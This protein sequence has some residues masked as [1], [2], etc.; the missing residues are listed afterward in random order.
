VAELRIAGLSLHAIGTLLGISAE[1]ICSTLRLTERSKWKFRITGA[2]MLIVAGCATPYQQHG[3]RGGYSDARI[4]QDSVLVSF[5]GNGYTS[6]ERVQLYLLYRCAEVTRQ[7][8]YD[9][10]VVTSGGTE[11]KVSYLSNYSA[12]TAASAYGTGNSA[13]GSAHTSGSGTTIPIN[14]YGTDAMIK[15]FKGHK[16]PDD[17][18]AYDARETLQYLGPQLKLSPNEP[19][20]GKD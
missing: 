10:F 8:G 17:P 11:G 5:K 20:P 13:F 9:Y 3:F 15:M 18:N 2:I 16:P 12:T 4:G 19:T 6:K 1:L 7:Y 14:K